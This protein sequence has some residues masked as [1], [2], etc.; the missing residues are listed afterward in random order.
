MKIIDDLFLD[1]KAD[2]I[3]GDPQEKSTGQKWD[4]NQLAAAVSVSLCVGTEGNVGSD[5]RW[6]APFPACPC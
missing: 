2:Y 5:H 1:M 4:R 6:T 3:L